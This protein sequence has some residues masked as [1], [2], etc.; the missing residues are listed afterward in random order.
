[1]TFG[2]WLTFGLCWT[3]VIGFSVFFVAKT[4][5]T[6]HDGDDEPKP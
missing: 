3:L 4:L 2:G 5:R 6:P 1:M